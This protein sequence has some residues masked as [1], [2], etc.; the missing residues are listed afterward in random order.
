MAFQAKVSHACYMGIPS[1]PTFLQSPSNS[2]NNPLIIPYNHPHKQ[3]QKW[4]QSKRPPSL[5]PPTNQ[6]QAHAQ[7]AHGK[8]KYDKSVRTPPSPPPSTSPRQSDP[9]LLHRSGNTRRAKMKTTS[10]TRTKTNKNMSRDM[11]PKSQKGRRYQT[12]RTM[13]MTRV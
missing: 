7:I 11:L 2:F 8:S 4:H 9:S 1:T 10:K 6:L 12:Q 13:P 3:P 5:H